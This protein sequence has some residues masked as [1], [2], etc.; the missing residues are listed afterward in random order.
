M[1][2][3]QNLNDMLFSQLKNLNNSELKGDDL[4]S[5][6]ERSKAF[7]TIARDVIENTKLALEVSKLRVEYGNSNEKNIHPMLGNKNG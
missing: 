4:K 1:N 3:L 5:E 7:S 6:I 2:D